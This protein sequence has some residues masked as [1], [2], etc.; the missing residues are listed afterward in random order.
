MGTVELRELTDEDRR[1]IRGWP[2]YPPDCL[3]LDYALREGGWLDHHGGHARDR[4]YAAVEDGE[5]V[6]FSI[7]H[8]GDDGEAEFMIALRGDALGRGLGR[9]V[10]LAALDRCFGELGLARV[11]L[12]V[13]KSNLRAQKLY[14]RIGFA[15]TGEC[16]ISINGK[17]V[18]FLN[19]EIARPAVQT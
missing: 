11:R 18:E 16:V 13:R 19:M 3:E 15:Y 1:A 10:T 7:I 12:V 14:C 5:V 2:T 9:Q 8:P 17:G 4:L 6:G